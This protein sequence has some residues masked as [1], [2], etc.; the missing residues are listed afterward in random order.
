MGRSKLPHETLPVLFATDREMKGREEEGGVFLNTRGIHREP[1]FGI[2]GLSFP[3]SVPSS[4][5]AK[6]DDPVVDDPK[7]MTRI[8]WRS[9]L[10]RG[11]MQSSGKSVLLFVHGYQ[12]DFDDSMR[13]AASFSKS[14]S[15][16]GVVISY[17]WPSQAKILGYDADSATLE[18]SASR[19][20]IVINEIFSHTHVNK[21]YMVAHS[22]GAHILSDALIRAYA[23]NKNLKENLSELIFAAPDIDEQYFKEEIAPQLVGIAKNITLYC[24]K[25]DLALSISRGLH[26]GYRRIGDCT[27]AISDLKNIEIIDASDVDTTLLGH[28]YIKTSKSITRDIFYLINKNMRARDRYGMIRIGQGEYWKYIDK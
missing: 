16:D 22:M 19:L 4:D 8:A 28:S 3:E 10:D 23:S 5:E 25:D 15:F 7:V 12:N 1:Y 17:S 27:G 11:I 14:I 26:G 21:V 13:A 24:S 6:E 9:A 2:V 20:A 18:S